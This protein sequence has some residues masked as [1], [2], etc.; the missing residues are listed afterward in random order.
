M[1]ANLLDLW[2]NTYTQEYDLDAGSLA[3]LRCQEACS[4]ESIAGFSSSW[5]SKWIQERWISPISHQP[6]SSRLTP[7]LSFQALLL[8]FLI[9]MILLKFLPPGGVSY[10]YAPYQISS[11]TIVTKL[12]SYCAEKQLC[13]AYFLACNAACTFVSG[14]PQIRQVVFAHCLGIHRTPRG[15]HV[16]FDGTRESLIW[17]TSL[18]SP[19]SLTTS[20]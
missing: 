19:F 14:L 16:I 15:F 9:P 2:S 17:T 11:Y 1:T 6:S 18:S 10:L 3:D 13:G 4:V 8:V 12:L 5:C 20:A 7:I